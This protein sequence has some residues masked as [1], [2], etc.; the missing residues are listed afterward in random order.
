MDA[1]GILLTGATGL[2]GRYLLRD[3]LRAGHTVTVLARDRHGTGAKERVAELGAFWSDALRADLPPPVVLHGD[4]TAPRLGLG[5]AERR[6][7]ARHCASA[8]H[9]AASVSFPACADEPWRTNADGTRHVIELC[10]E[11]GVARLHHV[12]TAFV[13]GE[14]AGPVYEHELACG[15]RFRNSYEASKFEAER[16]VRRARSIR[17]TVYRPSVIVGDSV[18]GYTSAYH[19][20]YYFAQ[21]IARLAGRS[22]GASRV[23]AALGGGDRPRRDPPAR[24]LPLRL[25]CTGR[26]TF[27]LVPVDWVSRALVRLVGHCGAPGKTYHLVSSHP[28][29]APWIKEVTEEIAGV[30][31]IGWGGAVGVRPPTALECAFL[32]QFREYTAYLAGAPSF[33]RR[34]TREALPQLA[35]PR[36]DRA[37][38]RRLFRF[39]AADDW[40]RR[41]PRPVPATQ[42]GAGFACVDYFERFLPEYSPRSLIAQVAGLNLTVGFELR[43]AGGGAWSCEWA[44]GRLVRVAR[45]VD[46]AADLTYRTDT[47]TFREVVRAALPPQEAFLA[48]RVEID[49]DTEKA[50]KLAV[51]FAHFVQQFPYASADQKETSHAAALCA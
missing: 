14:R 24:R 34:N 1:R 36:V 21:L 17:A 51:L 45:G 39:A 26:E 7:V 16:I 20:I 27:N 19:G 35:A 43:G 23:P 47:A 8:V 5:D 25:P 11:L 2:L 13:C 42:A 31:G 49:G 9:A 12:S 28:V 40:G 15:Q 37:L 10:E 33:D 6:W 18:T 22:P 48:R 44:G 46:A 29:P 3:L 50:L 30:E 32:E 38:L 41:R 4:L